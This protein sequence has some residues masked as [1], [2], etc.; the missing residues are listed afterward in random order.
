MNAPGWHCLNCGAEFPKPS[1][2]QGPK[3]VNQDTLEVD[4][5]RYARALC[6]ECL[7]TNIFQ[8]FQ[9]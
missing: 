8:P 9:S 6:P 2:S 5:W 7:S 1:I 3:H 4:R